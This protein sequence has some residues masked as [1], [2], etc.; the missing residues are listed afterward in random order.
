[1]PAPLP[2]T[3]T[4]DQRQLAAVLV[5]CVVCHRAWYMTDPQAVCIACRRAA[6]KRD[7]VGDEG[8]TR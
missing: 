8:T 2:A 6:A 3:S 7:D 4:Y 1:M 5:M